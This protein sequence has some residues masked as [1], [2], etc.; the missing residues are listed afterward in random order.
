MI[1]YPILFPAISRH[2]VCEN[3]WRALITRQSKCG[4]FH[5][6]KLGIESVDLFDIIPNFLIGKLN[7]ISSF[8]LWTPFKIRG[9][10]FVL[11]LLKSVRLSEILALLSVR[12]APGNACTFYF[13]YCLMTD[14]L[15]LKDFFRSSFKSSL[16]NIYI[17]LPYIIWITSAFDYAYL[18][19]WLDR[20]VLIA[21]L[22]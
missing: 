6:T 11:I 8:S 7:G 10:F 3:K 2:L 20:I 21:S 5:Y 4:C 12:A 15:F 22:N 14:V 18:I 13:L 1:Q 9:L 19:R 17:N 16:K